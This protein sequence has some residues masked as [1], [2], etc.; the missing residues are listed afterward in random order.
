MIHVAQYSYK[1][2]PKKNKSVTMSDAYYLLLLD[3]RCGE[4]GALSLS[5]RHSAR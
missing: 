3:F 2:K 4:S 5:A 1:D